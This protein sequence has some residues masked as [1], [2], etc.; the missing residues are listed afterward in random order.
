[1][2][3]NIAI[4]L[5]GGI[6]SRTGLKKPKQFLKISGKTILEHTI[7]I[8]EKHNKIDEIAI[9]AQE[10]N[11]YYIN[12]LLKKSLYKKV[13][14][15]L[16]AGNER[17]QSTLSALESYSDEKD[18]YV[19]IHDA[20]RP[21]LSE[22]I[23]DECIEALKK[24]DAIDVAIPSSD[25]IIEV[26]DNIIDNIPLRSR[27]YM[28]QTPQCFKINVLK[29]AYDLALKDK[30]FQVTD[31]CKV[32]VNY[33]PSTK[34][35]VVKGDTSNIK[36]THIEDLYLLEKLFQIKKID[37]KNEN[38]D[39]L[40][41]KNIIVFGGNSGIGKSIVEIASKYNVNIESYSRSNNCD[42]RNID[43]VKNALY[44]FCNKYK[45]IDAVIV[46]SSILKKES[47]YSSTYD[48]LFEQIDINYKGSIICAKESFNYLKES[49]G[50]LIF[51]TSSSYTLG[52]MD[53]SAYSS[54]KAAIV[55]FT[56]ALSEEWFDFDI[57]V[58]CVCPH[59]TST[60][61]RL[62]NFGIEDKNTLLSPDIVALKTLS[63]IK[64]NIYGNVVEVK[65][66]EN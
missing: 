21:L 44:S 31:D 54:S 60:P 25:T 65:I 18:S 6:G 39:F 9:V 62:K 59:R 47:L 11:H 63:I 33:L 66:D 49:R 48:D 58:N 36:L 51:F 16:C 23:I 7:D 56:Q 14:K 20:V 35:Y 52:R 53:Y 42:I 26:N 32:I 5:A 17:Y 12:E 15:I 41:N 10:E 8:F 43:D 45:S 27:M 3:R 34:V 61:M 57:K 19:I 2:I 37:I 30:N 28:G 4:I 1:M 38:L 46:C 22:S 50:H 13:K 24:Y 40:K 29:K 64:H 55:N